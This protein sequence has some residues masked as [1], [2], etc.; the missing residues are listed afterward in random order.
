MWGGS[1]SFHE[2]CCLQ[3]RGSLESDLLLADLPGDP[4]AKER[5]VPCYPHIPGLC[6]AQFLTTYKVAS[7]LED[8]TSQSLHGQSQDFFGFAPVAVFGICLTAPSWIRKYALL[9]ARSKVS[10]PHIMPKTHF[11]SSSL[12]KALLFWS[13]I[14]GWLLF[15][16]YWSEPCSSR[17][18]GHH[19]APLHSTARPAA[20]GWTGEASVSLPLVGPVNQTGSPAGN[21]PRNWGEPSASSVS[22]LNS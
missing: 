11:F 1:G 6:V 15:C 10:S 14:K 12:N 4:S 22:S 8:P 13:A 2:T 17:P 21:Q 7:V 3:I 5:V 9:A 18:S 19:S 20:P 16:N